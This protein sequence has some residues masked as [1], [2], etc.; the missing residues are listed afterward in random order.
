MLPATQLLQLRYIGQW[1]I[2]AAGLTVLTIWRVNMT[3]GVNCLLGRCLHQVMT[4]AVLETQHHTYGVRIF[5]A[6]I[7]PT[8]YLHASVCQGAAAEIL[9]TTNQ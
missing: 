7:V 9:P 1:Q 3:Y 2:E 5:I 8:S 6:H 4:C